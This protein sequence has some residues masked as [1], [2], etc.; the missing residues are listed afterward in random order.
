MALN[1][2]TNFQ[3]DIY[4]QLQTIQSLLDIPVRIAIRLPKLPIIQN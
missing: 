1:D 4:S 2:I 3:F